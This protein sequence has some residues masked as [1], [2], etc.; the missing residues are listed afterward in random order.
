MERWVCSSC[1]MSSAGFVL[2]VFHI[3]VHGTGFCG[4][5]GPGPYC[6]IQ[7]TPLFARL[8]PFGAGSRE[9]R[10]FWILPNPVIPYVDSIC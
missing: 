5:A 1:I 8:R 3:L 6:N 7:K 10:S 4:L 9:W 2:S